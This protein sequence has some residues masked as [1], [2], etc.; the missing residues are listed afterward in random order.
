LQLGSALPGHRKLRLPFLI[1]VDG[2]LLSACGALELF[3]QV[4]DLHLMP[5]KS[6]LG[7]PHFFRY[8]IQGFVQYG[9]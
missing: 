1:L 8:V 2:A 9:Q 7:Q 3:L 5:F 6:C 4:L